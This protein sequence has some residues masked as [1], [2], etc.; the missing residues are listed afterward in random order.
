MSYQFPP[1]LARLI[2]NHMATGRYATEEELL[3]DALRSLAEEDQDLA[4]VREAITEM[5]AGDRGIPLDEAF[6][7][8][9]RGGPSPESA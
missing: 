2:S 7:A 1:D 3:C 6:E 4:A 5:Q 8:V 9:R